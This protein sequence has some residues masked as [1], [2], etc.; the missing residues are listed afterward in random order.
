MKTADEVAVN[1]KERYKDQWTDP[2]A[3]RFAETTTEWKKTLKEVWVRLIH[4]AESNKNKF[5]KIA[6]TIHSMVAW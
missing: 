5:Y 3:D 6:Q 4:N 2:K 1:L